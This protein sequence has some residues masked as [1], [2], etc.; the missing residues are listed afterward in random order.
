MEIKEPVK[1]TDYKETRNQCI[2]IG[3]DANGIKVFRNKT[4]GTILRSTNAGTQDGIRDGAGTQKIADFYNGWK[5][6]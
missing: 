5:V 4:K 2:E 1:I 3:I 6:Y